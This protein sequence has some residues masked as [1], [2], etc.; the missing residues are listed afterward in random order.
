MEQELLRKLADLI[1]LEMGKRN[2]TCICFAEL[3]G[4]SRN[5]LSAIIN[6]KKT[7]ITLSTICKICEN[8]NIKVDIFF[9]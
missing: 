1:L 8:S 9:A 6:R 4:I 7:G 2:Q 3:C 5:E